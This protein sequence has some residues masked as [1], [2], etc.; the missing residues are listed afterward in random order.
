MA[1]FSVECV[2]KGRRIENGRVASPRS[3]HIPLTFKVPIKTA[4]DDIHK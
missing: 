1:R 4:A 3:V 2:Q